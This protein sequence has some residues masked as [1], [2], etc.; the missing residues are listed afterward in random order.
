MRV[1]FATAFHF[2][3]EHKHILKSIWESGRLLFDKTVNYGSYLSR[4]YASD[5]FFSVVS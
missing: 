2:F 4:C 1:N 3:I 5:F